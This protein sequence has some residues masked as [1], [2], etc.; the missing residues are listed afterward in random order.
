MDEYERYI[1]SIKKYERI[2]KDQEKDL[3][4]IIQSSE[5][6]KEVDK[7]TKELVE[8]N[9]FLVVMLFRTLRSGFVLREHVVLVVVTALFAAAI[10]SSWRERILATNL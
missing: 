1:K 3:S 7:A 2:T 5:D 9:L 6:Q 10:S 8:A 4:R